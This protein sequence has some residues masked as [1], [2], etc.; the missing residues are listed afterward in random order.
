M[1]LT[2]YFDGSFWCGLVEAE[3][4]GHYQAIRY[5]FGPEPKDADIFAFIATRLPHLL[6]QSGT[7]SAKKRPE[8]KVNPKRMQRLIN[9][10]KRQPV[11]ST[12]AQRAISDLREQTKADS[13]AL[14]RQKKAAESEARFQQRQVKK[15]EKHKG[16]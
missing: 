8:K 11:I 13:K 6:E 2:I 12:K 14:R 10:E 7:V 3:F 1:K 15:R 16:H 5:V 4:D 9:R